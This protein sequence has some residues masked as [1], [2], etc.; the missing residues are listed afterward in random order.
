MDL[1]LYNSLESS[2][3]KSKIQVP[4][5]EWILIFSIAII[6]FIGTIYIVHNDN[7]LNRIDHKKD[8]M[9]MSIIQNSDNPSVSNNQ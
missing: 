6:G 5:I 2:F 9:S 1:K 4:K 7:D 3:F 8:Q